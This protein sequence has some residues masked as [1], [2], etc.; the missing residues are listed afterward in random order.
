MTG[1][2]TNRATVWVGLLLW[3]NVN[4]CGLS[5]QSLDGTHWR[6]V[7]WSAEGE[8]PSAFQITAGFGGGRISGH[9]G[10]N[11]YG[12]EVS[13]PG[14]GGFRVGAVAATRMAGPPEAMAAESVY[15]KLLD[16]ARQFRIAGDE[17]LLLDEGGS[18]LLRFD[19]VVDPESP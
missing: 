19:R 18:E 9:S 6:L 12:G 10:V 14:S 16:L 17:L 8:F 11:R 1:F 5:G 2:L 13:F 4:S 15:L 7:A 3:L